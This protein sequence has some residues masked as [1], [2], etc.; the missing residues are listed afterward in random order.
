MLLAAG[1]VFLMVS[2]LPLRRGDPVNVALLLLA[3]ALIVL[4][5]IVVKRAAG[6]TDSKPPAG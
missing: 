5:P 4:A 2:I 6:S 3:G 1:I